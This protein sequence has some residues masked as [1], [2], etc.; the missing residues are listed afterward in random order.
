[1]INYYSKSEID[2]FT[3]EQFT[4]IRQELWDEGRDIVLNAPQLYIDVDVEADGIAGYGSMLSVG[5]QSPT[6]ESFYS[7]IK[8]NSELFIEGNRKF[9]EE[10][11]LER[12]RLVEE[13]PFL[14]DVMQTMSEWIQELR[15][16][17]GKDPVFTASN[18]GFDWA[19]VDL[20]FAQSGITN[21][22][23]IAPDDLK[24]LA[25]PLSEGWDWKQ[26]S[27]SNLP[28]IILPSEDFTHHALED[29]QYQQKIHFG[30]AA[31]LGQRP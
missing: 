20:S 16:I 18:A 22:F 6:G 11:G 7:E 27:K 26:T 28:K 14:Q 10:H 23:G 9:C 3:P 5:A 12:E 2:N 31:L 24:S 21:P 25:L 15:D 4:E 29:A 8:P 1:M 19:H 17:Y 13:A 30:L